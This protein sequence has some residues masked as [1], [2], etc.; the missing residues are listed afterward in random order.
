V[1][2]L[3]DV[4]NDDR[5]AGDLTR[6]GVRARNPQP[7]LA[8]AGGLLEA[9]IRRQFSSRGGEF[10]GRW[11]GTADLVDTGAMKGSLFARVAKTQVTVGLKDPKARL[12]Q[13]GTSRGLPKRQLVG[14]STTTEIHAMEIVQDYLLGGL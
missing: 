3:I 10:G 4:K 9:G 2:L 6:L 1:K 8:R 5:V 13:G 7:V 11:P 14:R 12:H